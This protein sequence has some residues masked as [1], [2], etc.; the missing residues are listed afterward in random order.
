MGFT[1]GSV[2]VG[3]QSWIVK[4]ILL[5]VIFTHDITSNAFDTHSKKWTPVLNV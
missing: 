3:L 5:D 4:I 1:P 2:W